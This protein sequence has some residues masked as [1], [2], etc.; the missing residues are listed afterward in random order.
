MTSPLTKSLLIYR[1]RRATV[2]AEQMQNLHIPKL[3]EEA[4]AKFADK[5][6]FFCGDQSLT[7]REVEQQ[8][9]AMAAWLQNHTQLKPGD[10]IAIQLPNILAFPIV[11]FAALRAGLVLVNTNPMYTPREMRHQFSDSG[12]KALVIWGAISGSLATIIDDTELELVIYVNGSVNENLASK[13]VV[14]QVTLEEALS[15]TGDAFSAPQLSGHDLCLLQ[16]TGGTTGKAKG[17]CLTHASVMSNT[18]QIHERLQKVIVAGEE[19][20]VCPLPLYH[21][22]AFA[23]NLI[24]FFSQGNT[25][26]LIPNPRDLDGFV[27][28]L[29]SHKFTGFAGINTLFVGLCRHEGFRQL[30]FS[31]LKLTISGGTALIDAARIGWEKV[32]GSTITEGYGMSETS[33]VICLNEPGEEHFGTVGRPLMGTTVEI[34][35]LDDLPLPDG[36]VGQIVVKGAQV[37][38]GYWNNLAE[39]EAVL[40]AD[41][42]FKTGDMGVILNDGCVQI[43]DRLKDMILVSGFNVYPSEVEQVLCSHPDVA[44]AAV[45]AVPDDNTGEAVK[46]FITSTFEIDMP[47]L[48]AYCRE[49]LTAYKVPKYIEQL[50]EL[51]KSAVGKILRKD[52]RTH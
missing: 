5:T 23:V 2:L 24:L 48:V 51:P 34:W 52:L 1:K 35:D 27:A 8:S 12:A 25:N 15:A 30:D 13:K 38:Q 28:Q 19:T 42:Y 43:V 20:F 45:I 6:A 29:K 32:T 9:K 49:N 41:R 11:A 50:K 33:P 7:Y 31:S 14:C 21:I 47:A 4:C 44:E 40:T 46:A 16:Y 26:I 18:L 22:Y 10:R 17:A 36:E 39:T 3:I 37:M